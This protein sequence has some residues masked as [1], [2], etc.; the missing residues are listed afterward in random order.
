MTREKK[1]FRNMGAP[2]RI[3]IFV[4]AIMLPTIILGYLA[5]RTAE[6]EKLVVW[7]K[8]RDSY[9]S[10]ASLVSDQLEN[11]LLASENDFQNSVLSINSYDKDSLQEVAEKIESRNPVVGHVFFL[12]S[13]GEMIFPEDP[14][15]QYEEIKP[16]IADPS[17]EETDMFQ[18]YLA[19]GERYEFKHDNPRDAIYEYS[20]ISDKTSF[21]SYRAIALNNMARCYN[22]LGVDH[23][24]AGI[25]RELIH[26]YPDASDGWIELAPIA[27]MRLISIYQESDDTAAAVEALEKFYDNLSHNRWGLDYEEVSYFADGIR[28]RLSSFKNSEDKISEELGVFHEN[29]TRLVSLQ[30]FLREY[31]LFA[32]YDMTRIVNNPTSSKSALSHVFRYTAEGAYFISYILPEGETGLAGFEVNLDYLS[33]AGFKQISESL[34]TKSDVVLAI[35]DRNDQIVAITGDPKPSIQISEP[36]HTVALDSLPFWKIGVYLENPKSL[37]NLSRNKVRLRILVIGGLVLAIVFGVYLILREARKEA[38]LARLRS[39][40]VANVSHELRTP[41]SSIQI[42]SETLKGKVSQDKQEQYL[43]TISSESDRLARLVDNVLN[44]SRLEKRS[45][46]FNFKPTDIGD[47][48]RKSVEAY[49]FYAEQRDVSIRLNISTNLPRIYADSEAIS[50][51]VMNLV[52]NAIKYSPENGVINVN[53]FRRGKTIL[54]RVSDRGIGIDKEDLDK[55]FDKFYRGKTA[56][57]LGT[58]GTG[59]GLTL[60]R[61]IIKAHGGDIK[62]RSKKGSGSRFTVVLPINKSDEMDSY[63]ISI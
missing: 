48:V 14:G 51:V 22:K 4:G 26:K 32:S 8:L 20:R 55:I 38:E 24:A 45:K 42:F 13:S 11:M 16:R 29:L 61:A 19:A 49:K 53:V 57:N 6:T 59:L 44:F 47:V 33:S 46:E 9:K 37:E 10:L 36:I 21:P 7:E 25:Y 5:I 40:F 62:V 17:R 39:D 28:K 12:D 63:D 50:Q 56:E 2:L 1:I 54:I 18:T 60:A 35:L 15:S 31:E 41:L 30:K 27:Y 34:D 3:I 52:D 23:E 43:H 58:G